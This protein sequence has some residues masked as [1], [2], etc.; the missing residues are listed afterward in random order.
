MIEIYQ[1]VQQGVIDAFL[2]ASTEELYLQGQ[3]YSVLPCIT[4]THVVS[5]VSTFMN[6]SDFEDLPENLQEIVLAAAS[7]IEAQGIQDYKA[8][9]QTTLQTLEDNPDV[10]VTL[11][12]DTQRAEWFDTAFLPVMYGVMQYYASEADI[13]QAQ[14]IIANVM[15]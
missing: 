15:G 1:N 8:S 5:A 2:W 14:A 10:N 11:L 4:I 3:L 6:E 12:S 9:W 7:D 13:A